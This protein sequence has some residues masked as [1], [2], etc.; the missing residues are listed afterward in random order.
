MYNQNYSD[1]EDSEIDF[2]FCLGK[3]ILTRRAA[4]LCF[5]VR[6]DEKLVL[7]KNCK[8][9]NFVFLCLRQRLSG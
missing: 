1:I 3:Q 6:F 2:I 8:K 9:L 7:R 5:R 4:K